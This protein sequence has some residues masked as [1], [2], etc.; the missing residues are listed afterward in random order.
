V[1]REDSPRIEKLYYRIG[2]AATLVGV[3]PHVLRHWET[4]FQT[5]RPRKSNSGQRI[6]TKEQIAMLLKVRTLLRDQRYTIAGA[7]RALRSGAV[8]TPAAAIAPVA[9]AVAAAVQSVEEP[10]PP[11]SRDAHFRAALADLRDQASALLR[12][13][14]DV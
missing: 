13:L 10:L 2:E 11:P 5:I 7:K 1:R 12:R 9:V 4:E 3:K 8:E 6:Y 14:D